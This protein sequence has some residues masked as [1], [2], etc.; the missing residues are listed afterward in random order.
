MTGSEK[1]MRSQ[2]RG[3]ASACAINRHNLATCFFFFSRFF[4]F[5]LYYFFLFLA[6]AEVP[7]TLISRLYSCSQK[8]GMSPINIPIKPP[9]RV[10][11]ADGVNGDGE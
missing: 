6:A 1:D 10:N 8:G 11:T 7:S 4:F 9:L 5:V 3:E 2:Q